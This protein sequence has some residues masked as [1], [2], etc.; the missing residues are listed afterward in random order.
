LLSKFNQQGFQEMFHPFP[1][2]C[3]LVKGAVG[4]DVRAKGNVDVK[5]LDHV[6]GCQS[7][8]L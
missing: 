7:T 1:S 6:L 4:A 2:P 5:V 3:F 8:G